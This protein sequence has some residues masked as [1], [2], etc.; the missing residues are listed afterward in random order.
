VNAIFPKFISSLTID[1]RLQGSRNSSAR[2]EEQ[3]LALQTE[4]GRSDAEASDSKILSSKSDTSAPERASHLPEIFFSLTVLVLV[5]IRIVQQY[6]SY[7]RSPGSDW[8]SSEWMID[9]AAGF[10]RRGLAGAFLTQVMHLTGWGFFPVWTTITTVAYLGLCAYI[11]KVSW[12]LGGPAIWRFALLLNPILLVSAAN[13]ASIARK[14]AFFVWAT[15]L[16]VILGHYVLQHEKA[17][18][19]VR[20]SHA[21]VILFAAILLSVALALLHE[22]IFLFTWLPLNVTVLAYILSRLRFSKRSIALL[23][24]LALTPA[25]VVVAAGAHWHGNAET[26]QAICLSWHSF[27]VPTVCSPGVGFPPAIDALSWSLSRGM[28]LSL[29][30]AWRFP[31]YTIFF[32]IAGSVEIITI[33]VLIRKARLEHLLALLLFPFAASLPLFLLGEDWGRWLCLVATSSL[34]VILSDQL[35]PALYCFL[36]TSFRTVFTQTIVPPIERRLEYF[37]SQVDRHPLLFCIALIMLPVPPYPSPSALG[38]NS[39]VIVVRFLH[40]LW[41]S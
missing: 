40:H 15:L 18:S 23:L 21:L 35:R 7:S 6:E 16:I 31:A 14:D 39:L 34:M 22:G 41:A 33:L 13:Y 3:S 12:R 1:Q 30:Y 24:A 19:T 11:L 17:K 10:V 36:P 8:N 20:V 9:Y 5:T 27:S 4:A 2:G 29:K 32:A 25:L 26:A 37:R 28:S 38:E